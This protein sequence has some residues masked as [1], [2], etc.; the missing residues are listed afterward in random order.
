MI[1][2]DLKVNNAAASTSSTM[3]VDRKYEQHMAAKYVYPSR[4]LTRLLTCIAI[5]D[6]SFRSIDFC[7]CLNPPQRSQMPILEL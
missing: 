5:W 2:D 1:T 4:Y 7:L 6:L 3:L